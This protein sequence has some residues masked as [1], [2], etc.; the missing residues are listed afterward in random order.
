MAVSDVVVLV[1]G[2]VTVSNPVDPSFSQWLN[3]SEP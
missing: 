1:L 2:T 3:V